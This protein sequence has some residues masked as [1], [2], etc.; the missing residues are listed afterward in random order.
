ME[1]PLKDS[2][3]PLPKAWEQIL[4]AGRKVSW[5]GE[6]SPEPRGVKREAGLLE[7]GARLQQPDIQE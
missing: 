3:F 4:Q 6:D 5:G 7:S 2:P 1:G